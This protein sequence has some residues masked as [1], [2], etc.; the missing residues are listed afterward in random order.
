MKGTEK[1][2]IDRILK[3]LKETSAGIRLEVSFQN[4]GVERLVEAFN[5]LERLA[6]SIIDTHLSL[7]H[8][9]QS[10]VIPGV[11]MRFSPV[12]V[13]SSESIKL[14][15]EQQAITLHTMFRD[16]FMAAL[17]GTCVPTNTSYQ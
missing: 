1:E 17:D 5:E 8:L 9:A 11:S 4:L 16:M 13:V 6:R 7:F 3:T 2:N 10:R 12:Q 15:T 14:L